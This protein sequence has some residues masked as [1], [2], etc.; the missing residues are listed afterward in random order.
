MLTYEAT[1][2]RASADILYTAVLYVCMCVCIYIDTYIHI[3]IFI[4]Y[5]SI[6][7][8]PVS[9]AADVW[10]RVTYADV[11]W[12]MLEYADV[13]WRMLTYLLHGLR[14]FGEGFLIG[15]RTLPLS[16]RHEH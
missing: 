8:S 5:L 6:Y 13:C 14:M 11:C 2:L 7:I 15:S 10:R 1:T 16:H 12:R 9:R 4:T 3:C